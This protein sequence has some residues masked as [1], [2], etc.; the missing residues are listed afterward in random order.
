MQL[1][2]RLPLFSAFS[3]LCAACGDHEMMSTSSHAVC[4]TEEIDAFEAKLVTDGV[5]VIPN[6]FSLDE[7]ASYR[8][9]YD[10]LFAHLLEQTKVLPKKSLEYISAFEKK[11]YGTKHYWD[12][13]GTQILELAPGRYDFTWGMDQDVFASEHFQNQEPVRTLMNRLLAPDFTHMSGALPSM[14]SSA[15]GPWHRDTYPLFSNDDHG[16][17]TTGLPEFYYTILIP[18][19]KLTKEN[20]TTEFIV[21]SHKKTYQQAVSENLPHF[22]ADVEPGSVIVFNGKIYHRGRENKTDV[23]RPVLYQVYHKKWYND[24]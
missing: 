20:G 23:D 10:R 18:L 12:Y 8:G 3:L 22:Q 1:H 5:V 7:I 11:A 19:V 4:A 6:V 2:S 15:N 17:V 16:Y 9:E 24:Y 21:G 13:E 14:S